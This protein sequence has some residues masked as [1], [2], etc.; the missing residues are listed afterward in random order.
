MGGSSG[1]RHAPQRGA[2]V[3]SSANSGLPHTCNPAMLEATYDSRSVAGGAVSNAKASGVDSPYS[4]SPVRD[5]TDVI[6]SSRSGCSIAMTCTIIPP[7][8]SPITWARS[9]PI[10]SSTAIP[11]AAMSEMLYASPCSPTGAPS[12]FDDRPTS[13]LSYRT[14]CSPR[15]ANISHQSS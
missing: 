4:G 1:R 6:D 9:T 3:S 5:I 2:S 11:S 13:R 15:P 8:D 14:T 10:A 12:N 7:I